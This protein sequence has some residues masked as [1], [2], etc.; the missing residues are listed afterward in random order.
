MEP[1][2]PTCKCTPRQLSTYSQDEYHT[3]I[4]FRGFSLPLHLF[5]RFSHLLSIA[6]NVQLNLDYPDFFSGPNLVMNIYKSQY[7]QDP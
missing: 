2:P 1:L 6:Y 3:L 4:N 5:Q 7:H